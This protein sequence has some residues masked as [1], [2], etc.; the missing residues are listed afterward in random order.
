MLSKDHLVM[1]GAAA[2]STE[3]IQPSG[4]TTQRGV[5]IASY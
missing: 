2:T 1:L 4:H 3:S 5:M